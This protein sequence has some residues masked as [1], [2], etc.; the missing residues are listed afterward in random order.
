MGPLTAQIGCPAL[1]RKQP[2]TMRTSHVAAALCVLATLVVVPASVIAAD[3]PTAESTML[4]SEW[5]H[6]QKAG[7]SSR[8]K[9]LSEKEKPET[10]HICLQETRQYNCR[11]VG[12]PNFEKSFGNEAD[13]TACNAT[14]VSC[15]NCRQGTVFQ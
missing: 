5:F 2:V 14:S 12:C 1:T 4:F 11:Y 7:P 3:L 8:A 15:V 6:S 13:P 9:V 10:K